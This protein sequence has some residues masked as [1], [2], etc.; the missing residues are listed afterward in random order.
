MAGQGGVQQG[1]VIG[2][3]EHDQPVN[4]GAGDGGTAALGGGR[5]GNEEQAAA[6]LFRDG[7]D[8]REYGEGDRVVEGIGERIV[9]CE[10][11]R[12]DP[13][14][15]QPGG[16]RVRARVPEAGGGGEHPLPGGRRELIG[17]G[18]GVGDSFRRYAHFGCYL[19]KRQAVSTRRRPA[20]IL[21]R[22]P[23]HAGPV[24]SATLPSSSLKYRLL[25]R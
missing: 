9:V 11:E 16:Q 23:S 15:A 13:A 12:A 14:P 6:G 8:A 21:V 19:L 24:T 2:Y 10:A 17:A 7:A 20:A 25:Q 3:G 4:D 1:I 5:A 22:W 18:E